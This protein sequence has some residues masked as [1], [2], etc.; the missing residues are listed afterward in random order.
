M[1]SGKLGVAAESVLYHE[2]IEQLEINNRAVEKNNRAVGNESARCDI[3]RADSALECEKVFMNC[4][5]GTE[6]ENV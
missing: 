5:G 1:V 4:R 3:G 2:M 6:D